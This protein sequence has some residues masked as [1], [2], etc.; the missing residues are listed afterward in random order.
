MVAPRPGWTLASLRPRQCGPWCPRSHSPFSRF[1][2]FPAARGSRCDP[3]GPRRGWGLRA[4]LETRT[5]GP[6]DPP[7]LGSL[8]A[9]KER[10]DVPL[11][12]RLGVQPPLQLGSLLCERGEVGS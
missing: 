6:A 7:T 12:L 10:G 4:Q 2:L 5:P 11:R 8:Q 9:E 1:V 3:V